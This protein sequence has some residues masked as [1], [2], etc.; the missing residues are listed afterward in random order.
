MS[1]DDISIM[2]VV[3][4]FFIY[5]V[6]LATIYGGCQSKE[7]HVLVNY[8][9][10]I[11]DDS[12][13]A[14]Q[15]RIYEFKMD[16][17]FEKT[18]TFNAKSEILESLKVKYLRIA[19]GLDLVINGIAQPYLRISNKVPCII[20]NHPIFDSVKICFVRYLN[21]K[22]YK[23]IEFK[24]EEQIIDGLIATIYLS[25]D[26]TLIEKVAVVGS[27]YDKVLII[28]KAVIPSELRRV[29]EQEK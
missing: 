25:N 28:D 3:M 17:I 22:A 23:A 4:R 21:Y 14:Y 16:S 2:K 8:Y 13:V 5:I 11:K 29:L 18:I 24:Y 15:Q 10:V 1:N 19:D 12:T 20:S 27:S 6:L 9:R 26:Y 7:N